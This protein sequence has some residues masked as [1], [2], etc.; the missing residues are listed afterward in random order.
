MPRRRLRTRFVNLSE[1]DRGRIIRMREAGMSTRA[2]A[3]RVGRNQST[4]VRVWH[5]WTQDGTATRR[6]VTGRPRVTTEREDRRIVRMA[7]SSRTM[8]ATQIRSVITTSVSRRTVNNRLLQSG[9]CSRIPMRCLPL[10]PYHR[11]QT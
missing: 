8:T 10:T 1:F 6:P 7:T 11:R 9:L 4:V 2:V 3:E 5:H